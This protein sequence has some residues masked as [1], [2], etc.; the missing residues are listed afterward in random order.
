MTNNKKFKLFDSKNSHLEIKTNINIKKTKVF[1]GKVER[2]N[3]KRFC[4]NYM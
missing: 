2:P 3:D 1:T 4:G